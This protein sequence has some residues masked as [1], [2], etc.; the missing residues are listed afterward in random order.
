MVW[1]GV[2]NIILGFVLFVCW[3]NAPCY[4]WCRCRCPWDF[5][6]HFFNVSQLYTS[7]L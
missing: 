6:P 5:I 4:C 1:L 2:S 7:S 3:V